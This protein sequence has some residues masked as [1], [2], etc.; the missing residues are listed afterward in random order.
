MR[1]DHITI[2]VTDLEASEKF[3]SEVLG[4][5]RL[6]DVDMGDHRLHYFEL[7]DGA[8]LELIDYDDPAGELHPSVKTMGIYRHLAFS[9]EDVDAVYEKA[10]AY[11]AEI[12]AA[13][14][15]VEKLNFR[16]ILIRDPNGVELEILHRY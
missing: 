16:N 4:L 8:M 14:A 5:K 10:K 12:F 9:V 2:N 13:P 7:N 1:I 15:D 6:H 3:Y 11:G